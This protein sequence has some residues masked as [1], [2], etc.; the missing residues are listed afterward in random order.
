MKAYIA[1]LVAISSSGC[2]DWHHGHVVGEHPVEGAGTSA[3]SG[4]SECE[5]PTVTTELRGQRG[6]M[7]I[8]VCSSCDDGCDGAGDSCVTYGDSCDYFGERGVCAACC[9]G[10]RGELR[11]HPVD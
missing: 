9:N 4:V 10:E 2:S 6:T 7:V 11:C 1:L 8:A 5:A 3:A